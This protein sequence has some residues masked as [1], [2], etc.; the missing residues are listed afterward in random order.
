MVPK[1]TV[2]P[3]P[4]PR[5]GVILIVP[6]HVAVTVSPG[7]VATFTLPPVRNKPRPKG[8]PAILPEEVVQ[9]AVRTTEGLERAAIDTLKKVEHRPTTR[10]SIRNR[11]FKEYAPFGEFGSS[12]MLI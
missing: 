4:G 7:L 6:G 10:T 1:K 9:P 5:K 11:R 2:I 8:K 3:P 12:C